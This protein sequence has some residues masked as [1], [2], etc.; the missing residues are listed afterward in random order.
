VR[1]LVR[2]AWRAEAVGA[3]LTLALFT[4]IA[5]A[6]ADPQGAW[7]LA[8]IAASLG[9][10]YAVPSTLLMGHAQ[11]ASGGPHRARDRAPQH[12]RPPSSC[13]RPADGSSQCSPWRRR[14]QRSSLQ[15]SRASL[16]GRA[17]AGIDGTDPA[18]KAPMRHVRRFTLLASIT[19]V[20]DFVV[21]RRSEFFFPQPLLERHAD[22]ALL[23]PLCR[24]DGPRAAA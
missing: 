4:G 23:D 14:L 21:W 24:G 9:V 1:R 18:A 16:R 2:W 15:P 8:G 10:L 11:M 3:G 7:F 6:G 5:A 20:L 12:V 22:R 19:A 13:S 17:L